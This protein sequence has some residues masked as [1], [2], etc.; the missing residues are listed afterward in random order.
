MIISMLDY[1]KSKRKTNDGKMTEGSLHNK[2]KEMVHKVNT[3]NDTDEEISNFI[4]DSFSDGDI[5]MIYNELGYMEWI[6]FISTII[7]EEISE[8]NK[9]KPR[10]KWWKK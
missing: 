6:R 2:I 4:I 7:K 8:R 1:L 3:T 9:E 5:I 10:T